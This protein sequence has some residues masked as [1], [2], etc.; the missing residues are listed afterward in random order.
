[1]RLKEKVYMPQFKYKP[2][3][4]KLMEKFCNDSELKK[5]LSLHDMFRQICGNPFSIALAAAIYQREKLKRETTNCLIS[6]YERIRTE[7]N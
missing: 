1:M 3:Y 2:Q 6:V 7:S 5:A 4:K